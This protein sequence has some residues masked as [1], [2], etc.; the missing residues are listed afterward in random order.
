[1]ITIIEAAQI[2][3]LAGV[4]TAGYA[5]WLVSVAMVKFAYR[6]VYKRE[7]EQLVML[8]KVGATKTGVETTRIDDW[9]LGWRKP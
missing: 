3:I 4:V 5:G 8:G 2:V 7:R 9:K 1:M 6:L